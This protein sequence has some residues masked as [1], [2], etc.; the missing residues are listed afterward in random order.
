MGNCWLLILEFVEFCWQLKEAGSWWRAAVNLGTYA[1]F[2]DFCC[3]FL[4][5]EGV[6][7]CFCSTCVA[8][9]PGKTLGICK[10]AAILYSIFQPFLEYEFPN[11]FRLI[12]ACA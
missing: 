11:S 2:V 8:G 5:L 9:F 10:A 7:D 12:T 6:F 3:Q 1:G 4:A